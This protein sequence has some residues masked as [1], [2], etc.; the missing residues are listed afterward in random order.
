M[1]ITLVIE[2]A[3]LYP[4]STRTLLSYRDIQ[5]NGFHIET[6][7]DNNEE[8]LFITKNSG[9][10]KET[11]EKVPSL[12]SRLYFTYLKPIQHVAYKVIF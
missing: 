3:L 8:F 5:K 2:D 9:Y 6:Y 4:D 12:L 11:L 10:G 1:G 7:D